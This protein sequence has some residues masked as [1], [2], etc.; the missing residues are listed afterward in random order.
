MDAGFYTR[1]IMRETITKKQLRDFGLVIG[2][3]FPLLIGWLLPLLAGH[4]FSSWTL[5]VGGAALLLGLI[6]PKLLFYPYKI[7]M[8]LGNVLGWFNSKFIFTIVFIIVLQPIAFVMRL[9]GY[10]PLRTKR[11]GEKTFRE[12]RKN[13]QT[14]LTRIF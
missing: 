4:E 13:H 2:F 7:W 3:G 1:L 12:K 8:L 14:D 11:N 5:W 6:S 9:I 10:D